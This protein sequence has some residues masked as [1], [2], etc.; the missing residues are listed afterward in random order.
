MSVLNLY[1]SVFW[2]LNTLRDLF[3]PPLLS[4]LKR[5]TI[6]KIQLI[7]SCFTKKFVGWKYGCLTTWATHTLSHTC[8]FIQFCLKARI[9]NSWL[10]LYYSELSHCRNAEK[11]KDT[12]WFWSQNTLTPS[13]WKQTVVSHW[14]DGVQATTKVQAAGA[15]PCSAA[16]L[17]SGAPWSWEFTT[18]TASGNSA[19]SRETAETSCLMVTHRYDRNARK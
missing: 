7:L 10:W 9:I 15:P 3:F 19:S 12:T 13:Y 11:F 4:N 14:D 17:L 6:F 18:N 2:D 8:T 5:G 1:L 16:Q